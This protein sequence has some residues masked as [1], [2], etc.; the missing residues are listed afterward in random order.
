METK[1]EPCPFCG[2]TDIDPKFSQGHIEIAAGCFECGAVGPAVVWDEK[3]TAQSESRSL[4]AWNA[5]RSESK[6][7]HE[8]VKTQPNRGL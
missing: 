1:I 3:Q 7:N 8:K 5:R 4:K 6:Q 2:G